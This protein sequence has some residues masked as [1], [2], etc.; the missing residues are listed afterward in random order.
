MNHLLDATHELLESCGFQGDFAF[1]A[2]FDFGDELTQR[3]Q[4][5]IVGAAEEEIEFFARCEFTLEFTFFF[6]KCAVHQALV[7][8]QE[9]GREWAITVV[10]RR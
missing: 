9:E 10:N 2:F 3:A 1:D 7:E 8:R 4:P 6:V 5:L